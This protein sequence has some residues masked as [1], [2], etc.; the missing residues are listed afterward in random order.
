MGQEVRVDFGLM[1][2][3]TDMEGVNRRLWALIVI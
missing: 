3:V 1:G 2:R